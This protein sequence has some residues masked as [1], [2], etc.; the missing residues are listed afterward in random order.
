[1]EVGDKK[2]IQLNLTHIADNLIPADIIPALIQDGV[3][4]FDDRAR[5]VN[6]VSFFFFS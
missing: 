3:F 5:I 4:T 6:Q 1:M 2:K